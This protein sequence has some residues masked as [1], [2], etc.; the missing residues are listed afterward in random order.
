[1]AS[2]LGI[3]VSDTARTVEAATKQRAEVVFVARCCALVRT[4]VLAAL[5]LLSWVVD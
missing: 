4:S 3:D 2:S 5:L 1:M